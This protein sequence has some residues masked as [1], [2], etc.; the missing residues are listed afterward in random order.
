VDK[1]P[2]F[3]GD[4]PL[5][6]LTRVERIARDDL[7]VHAA[8]DDLTDYRTRI[9]IQGTLEHDESVELHATLER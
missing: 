5:D 4:A 2:G 6:E 1:L 7:E 3:F 9:R 8:V